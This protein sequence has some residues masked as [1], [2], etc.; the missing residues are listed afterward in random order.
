MSLQGQ[1]GM[2]D[3]SLQPS[4]PTPVCPSCGVKLE[5]TPQHKKKCPSCGQ[6]IYVRTRPSD[7]QRVLVNEEE[8][9]RIDDPWQEMHAVNGSIGTY[10]NVRQD[11]G[12]L[13]QTFGK[14]PDFNTLNCFSEIRLVYATG[15]SD[16]ETIESLIFCNGS[17][18]T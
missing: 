15:Q 11:K 1:I 7:K 5:V 3:N 12:E 17:H 16:W 10:A 4:A 2:N 14:E 6:Y 9:N 13:T 18:P 8:A